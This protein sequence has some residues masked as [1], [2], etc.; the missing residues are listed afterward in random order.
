MAL[1]HAILVSL[2]DR[3]QSG[4]DL[5][6]H[7]DQ[8]VGYFWKAGHQ[9]IY[10]ELHKLADA[11]L[12]RSEKVAQSTRPDRYIYDVTTQ[13][14]VAL[15]AWIAEPT[16]APNI[17]EEL[18]VKLF[19]LGRADT[20]TLLAE[21]ESRLTFHRDRLAHYEQTMLQFYA[22]PQRLPARR[23]G[24]YLG[25]RMGVLIERGTVQWCEEAA[26]M[27]AALPG[28]RRTAAVRQPSPAPR[29]RIAGK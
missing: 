4:Y 6:K 19:A 27:V 3:P 5:T 21:I 15:E 8:T 20:G 11:G 7:F 10:S 25:L 17:K 13:G 2:L 12:V 29:K 16:K 28:R 9:Q 14:E 24:H 1:A 26:A 22:E 23:R 18:L